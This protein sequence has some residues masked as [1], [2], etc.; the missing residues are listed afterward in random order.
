MRLLLRHRHRRVLKAV[1]GG[2]WPLAFAKGGGRLD[3]RPRGK[4]A[5]R[6]PN[7]CGGAA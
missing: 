1:L 3:H 6:D 7:L 2:P 4:L 5:A